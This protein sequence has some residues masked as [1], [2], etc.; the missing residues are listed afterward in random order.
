MNHRAATVLRL[1]PTALARERGSNGSPSSSHASPLRTED[2][3]SANKED[4][5]HMTDP[6]PSSIVPIILRN[7]ALRGELPAFRFLCTGEVDGPI[8]TLSF[9]E[10]SARSLAIASALRRAGIAGERALLLFPPGLDFITAFVGCLCAGV[11]A[12]PAYPPDLRQLERTL[13]RLRAIA[14]DCQP[15]VVLTSSAVVALVEGMLPLLPELA[16]CAVVATDQVATSDA[17]GLGDCDF[18]ASQVAFLQYTSGSTGNPKGV[19]V[20]H[21]NLLAN[22]TALLR[23]T[24]VAQSSVMV[25]W[26]PSYHDMGLITGILEA[27]YAGCLGILL[28]PLDFLKKPLRWLRAISHFRGTASPFPNFALDLCTKKATAADLSQLD[29]RSWQCAGNGAE[30][31]RPG[32]VERFAERFAPC[33]FQRSAF[34]PVYGLAE[35][36]ILVAGERAVAEVL[37]RTFNRTELGQKRVRPTEKGSTDSLSLV[38]CGRAIDGHEVVIVDPQTCTPAAGDAVGEIWVRGP[39]VAAGYWGRPEESRATFAAKLADSDEGPFLRTG[40]LGFLYEGQL[41]FAGRRK[42]TLVIRGVNYYPQ[43]IEE[44]VQQAH[45]SIRP[46]SIAAVP[47]DTG[48]E[49]MLG[50]LVEVR[51]QLEGDAQREVILRIRER[52]LA[53]V[54]LLPRRIVLLPQGTLLKTSSGKLQRA[55]CRDALMQGAFPRIVLDVQDD[56]GAEQEPVAVEP[57]KHPLLEPVAEILCRVT[58]FPRQALRPDVPLVGV[59][60]LDSLRIAEIVTELEKVFGPVGVGL[61][62]DTGMTLSDLVRALASR[63]TTTSAPL[64]PAAPPQPDQAQPSSLD[65]EVESTP[66]PAAVRQ[67]HIEQFDEV[68]EL[69]TLLLLFKA[70]KVENPYWNSV[71]GV[72]RDTLELAGAPLLNFATYNYLGLCGDERVNAAAMAAIRR[73]GTSASASRVASGDRPIHRELEHAI[74]AFLGCDDSLVFA[75][76]HATNVTALATLCDRADLI[77]H[78]SLAHNS[79]VQGA[80]LSGARR[81][82]FPH[83]DL[84]A[85]ERLLATLRGTARRVLIA[86]EGAYSMDGDLAPL[87]A[88]VALKKRYGA[89]LYVDEAHSLGCVGATGRGIAEQ[90]GVA[91]GDVDVWMGTLSKALASC[92]GYVAGSRALIEFLKYRGGG[93]VYAAAISPQNAAAAKEALRILEAEPERVAALQARAEYFL[94][95]C[96]TR[97]IDTGLSRGTAIVPALVGSS[98]RCLQ[99]A[100]SLRQRGINVPPIFYPAVEEGRA[101]LR[102]FLSALHSEAQLRQAAESLAEALRE[103]PVATS[104]PAI[105][106]TTNSAPKVEP[107]PTPSRIF[108]RVFVTG[109]SGF[110]GSRVVKELVARGCEVRCLLRPTSKAHRLAGLRYEVCRGDLEDSSA[111]RAGVDGCDAIVHLACASAWSEIRVLGPR[112]HSV[113]VDGTRNVLAA[114]RQA[115]VQRLV[116]VSSAVAVNG[117]DTP[118]LF[119]ETSRYELEGRGLA[120]SLAKRRAEE[121]VLSESPPL[122]VVIAA[123]SEVYGP[124]DDGLV[125]AGSILDILHAHTPIACAG[126]TSIAH[127]DDVAGGIVAAL[128]RGRPSERYILGG[129][130]LTVHELT[131][132]VLRLAGRKDAVL[133]VPNSALFDLV[134]LLREAGMSPPI[135]EDV[136]D[137]A[138]LYWFMDSSKARRE[139]GYQS[140]DAEDTL[141]SVV[142]WLRESSRFR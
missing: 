1:P 125:T 80:Q 88:L 17:C 19:K 119:D 120:Y 58:A 81:L 89:L 20:T 108:R 103:H 31:I 36:T 24:Q 47:L 107:Q 56:Q 78:D 52:V 132:T 63:V 32:T 4:W 83:Q 105:T 129:P 53:E 136:L 51:D 130:N 6:T 39:S 25:C 123:P 45:D 131:R 85:L 64:S 116:Y 35:S 142:T 66:P 21:G 95:L 112:I 127:V 137:Y 126:G 104:T 12:V 9:A 84:D 27:L 69:R 16:A 43:D 113:S 99:V 87:P 59:I 29:L 139:L 40:D 37:V 109:G 41:F 76:G 101:R 71:G 13:P 68:H 46:G 60:G 14:G 133:D 49:E 62:S 141:R 115:G 48:A 28:S 121:L 8:D 57:P 67:E 30:A 22:L 7:A 86:V 23:V 42:D 92:G 135:S 50:L 117:S 44:V 128:Y 98:V 90:A 91:R 110:I 61:F 118:S 65:A 97:G 134:R 55:A 15:R 124:G 102:F 93:M 11:I 34:L 82:V 75:S 26:L 79:I 94:D 73:Y 2:Q 114:A 38:G 111:L 140:R 33:G 18:P 77:L 10:L 72:A 138:T 96:R 100:D 54:G 106:A 74:A 70:L 122:E 5:I 3:T